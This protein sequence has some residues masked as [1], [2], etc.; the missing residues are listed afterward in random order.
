MRRNVGQAREIR[1]IP[2]L[3]DWLAL[4][5]LSP[6]LCG[7]LTSRGVIDVELPSRTD[8]RL[9]SVLT[10]QQDSPVVVRNYCTYAAGL[11]NYLA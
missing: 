7:H 8:H 4:H 3:A 10:N 5:Y 2:P 6:N 11:P 9:E 1:T